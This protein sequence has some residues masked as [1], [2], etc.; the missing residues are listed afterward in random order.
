M[1]DKMIIY[2]LS[3]EEK[4]QKL[5]NLLLSIDEELYQKVEEDYWGSGFNV[6]DVLNVVRT[7]IRH[8]N[9]LT[10]RLFDTC[11]VDVHTHS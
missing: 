1:E 7:E 3:N 9:Y 5:K 10:F 11:S 6:F 4:E 8:S 2:N